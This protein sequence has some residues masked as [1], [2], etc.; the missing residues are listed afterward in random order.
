MRY[1]VHIMAH[2]ALLCGTWWA[3]DKGDNSLSRC[4]KS[5]VSDLGWS[6]FVPRPSTGLMEQQINI[7]KLELFLSNSLRN[8]S[9]KYIF[10]L[11]MGFI[12]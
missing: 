8:Y 10:L 5:T 3:V 12:Q 9:S 7:H 1:S 11:R 4:S 2:N 6:V